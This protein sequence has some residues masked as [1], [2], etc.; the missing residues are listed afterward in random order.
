MASW[1]SEWCW[2]P[3]FDLLLLLSSACLTVPPW[4]PCWAFSFPEQLWS[5]QQRCSHRRSWFD[6]KLGGTGPTCCSWARVC[7]PMLKSTLPAGTSGLDG[8]QQ[9]VWR[10]RRAS[11]FPRHLLNQ[12]INLR[13]LHT[14]NRHNWEYQSTQIPCYFKSRSQGPAITL[15][16][17]C[18][19]QFIWWCPRILSWE[20]YRLTCQL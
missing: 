18:F 1:V 20:W 7:I 15:K 14:I 12:I 3:S 16:F 17:F 5:E 13:H 6:T 4:L 19:S 2:S 11:R 8:L 9:E 10:G